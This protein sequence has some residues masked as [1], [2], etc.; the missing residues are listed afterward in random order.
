VQTA[1]FLVQ[2]WSIRGALFKWGGEEQ[3]RSRAASL[4][5]RLHS[6]PHVHRGHGVTGGGHAS[7]SAPPS[8]QAHKADGEQECGG[9]LGDEGPACRY[10]VEEGAA[11]RRR[12]EPTK[13]V[14]G[15]SGVTQSARTRGCRVTSGLRSLTRSLWGSSGLAPKPGT[16]RPS[17]ISSEW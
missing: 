6:M 11:S 12:M 2:A 16:T 1:A 3:G 13:M 17:K 8:R 4:P 14:S 10:G 7:V 9:G 5:A 15:I